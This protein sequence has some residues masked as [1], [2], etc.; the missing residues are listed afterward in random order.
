MHTLGPAPDAREP[1]SAD[2]VVKAL[3]SDPALAFEVARKIKVLGPWEAHRGAWVRFLP[4]GTAAVDVREGWYNDER[5]WCVSTTIKGLR[6][7]T[8]PD[9]GSGI[10]VLV[11]PIRV[12]AQDRIDA[13]LVM[14]GYALVEGGSAAPTTP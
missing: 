9:D 10:R 5:M 14:Y 6:S 4:D 12:V 8:D 2:R 1:M 3:A 7:V 11:D 13:I